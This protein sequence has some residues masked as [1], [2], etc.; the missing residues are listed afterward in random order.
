MKVAI[1]LV[2]NIHAGRQPQQFQSLAYEAA[3]M[4][5]GFVDKGRN[6]LL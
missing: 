5:C 3:A 6:G 1:A 2:Q 4:P